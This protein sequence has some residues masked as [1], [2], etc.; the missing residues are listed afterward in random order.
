M[1]RTEGTG[2]TEKGTGAEGSDKIQAIASVL[3]LAAAPGPP[4]RA[5][6]GAVNAAASL[7]GGPASLWRRGEHGVDLVCSCL[8]EG[9]DS[10]EKV[11]SAMKQA[12]SDTVRAH[13]GGGGRETEPGPGGVVA[14]PVVTQRG[15]W[16]SLVFHAPRPP[17]SATPFIEAISLSIG[18]AAE[19]GLLHEEA[20]SLRGRVAAAERNR[21]PDDRYV[22]I[23]Q[24]AVRAYDELDAILRAVSAHLRRARGGGGPEC[25]ECV[26]ELERAREIV[27]EQ[28]DLAKLEMPVLEMRDMNEVVQ[29]SLREVEDKVCAK[30]LSLIKRLSPDVPPI[31]LD[32][33]KVKLAVGKVMACAVARSAREGR[34][35]VETEVQGGDVRFQ[36]GWEESGEAADT[37]ENMFE[38]FGP[39]DRGGMGFAVASQIIRE[40]GGGVHVMRF[41]GGSTA[42]AL[43]F[44]IEK[45]QERRRRPSRRS[46]LDRRRPRRS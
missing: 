35:R 28:S 14:A 8:E 11:L 18:L 4:E 6:T 13:A 32:E 9:G 20:L 29:S 43:D 31:L 42:L 45:N 39:L 19:L 34:L 24:L 44:P 3:S 1:P 16:G 2:Y 25:A 7:M 36:V 38:P 37:A 21:K 40:H 26:S 10:K 23:G 30:G 46:G 12:A 15:L 27:A 22:T 41:E 17:E 5:Y 33:K